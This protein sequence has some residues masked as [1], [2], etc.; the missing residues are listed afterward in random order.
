ADGL[1]HRDVVRFDCCAVLASQYCS[2]LC[3]DLC[4]KK[5]VVVVHRRSVSCTC[6]SRTSS[7]YAG[8]ANACGICLKLRGCDVECLW[9]AVVSKGKAMAW[10]ALEFIGLCSSDS[11]CRSGH[12]GAWRWVCTGFEYGPA[13]SLLGILGKLVHFEC[14]RQHDTGYRL[15]DLVRP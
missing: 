9:A 12:R 8:C 7:R 5:A 13:A 1:C 15:F 6:N 2:V 3:P 4:P 11:R 14:P 10:Y